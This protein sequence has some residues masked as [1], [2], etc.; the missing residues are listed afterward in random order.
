MPCDLIDVRCLGTQGGVCNNEAF[1]WWEKPCAVD[2]CSRDRGYEDS[3]H[4]GQ[5]SPIEVTELPR[6]NDAGCACDREPVHAR[7]RVPTDRDLTPACRGESDQAMLLVAGK[8]VEDRRLDIPAWNELP[9]AATRQLSAN[10]SCTPP[11]GQRFSAGHEAARLRRVWK[12]HT[13]HAGIVDELASPSLA[14]S[15]GG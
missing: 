4:G 11:R 14:L 15:T 1:A 2:N 3:V 13:Q 7:R 12:W 6:R 10:G 5:I 8:G 9:P